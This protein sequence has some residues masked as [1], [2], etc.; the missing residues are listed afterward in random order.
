MPP[1]IGIVARSVAAAASAGD[2]PA[3]SLPSATATRRLIG[4]SNSDTPPCATV[5]INSPP[6][7]V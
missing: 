7:A 1:G 2:R 5:A 4:A 6:A 3:P